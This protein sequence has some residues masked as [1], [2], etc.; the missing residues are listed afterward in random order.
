MG[1]LTLTRKAAPAF[2]ESFF[3]SKTRMPLAKLETETITAGNGPV[4]ERGSTVQCHAKGSVLKEGSLTKFWSTKDPGQKPFGFTAGVGQVIKGWDE[5]VLGMKTGEV[6][7][8]S[9]PAAMGYGG[10]GFPSWNIG[11]NSDLQFEIE[12]LAVTGKTDL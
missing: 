10:G 5:G 8:I 1:V 4:V 11:P 2:Q 6:R 3:A 12:V 9:I 7:K